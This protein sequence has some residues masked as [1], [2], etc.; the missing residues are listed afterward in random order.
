MK[1][2]KHLTVVFLAIF[3]LTQ[4]SAQELKLNN[5]SSS[6]TVFGT[7]NVH[8]WDVKAEKK[9]GAASVA[10]E[11]GKL[12]AI[13]KLTFVVEVESLKSGKSG[14]DKNTYKALNSDKHKNITFTSTRVNSIA[15]SGSNQY[16]VDMT[17]N[18]VINGT[19]KQ[20][21]LNVI[22]TISGNT[23]ALKGNYTIN[24]NHYKVTP[25]TALMG[26]IKTGD[27]VKVEFEVKYQ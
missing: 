25:P 8:D 18:L 10:I 27:T 14:M 19:S 1:T 24:M 13:N 12:S 26:T 5:N 6:V 7:S 3:G 20:I 9:S 22:A 17:G 21:P 11:D 15:A 4:V 16:K 23:V 2:L